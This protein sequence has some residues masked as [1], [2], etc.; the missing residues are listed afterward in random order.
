M[1]DEQPIFFLSDVS[2]VRINGD[3]STDGTPLAPPS[4][5][6]VFGVDDNREPLSMI[7]PSLTM[8]FT[9]TG[10][11]H[12]WLMEQFGWRTIRIRRVPNAPAWAGY[13]RFKPG[14]N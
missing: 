1:S 2:L 11:Q 14:V 4:A 12:R 9:L 13:R 10:E 8:T 5:V 7:P 6:R 3:D